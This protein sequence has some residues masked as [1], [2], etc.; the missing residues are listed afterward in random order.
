MAR[1]SCASSACLS[2]RVCRA[3]AR[4][5]SPRANAM[6]PC[7]RH[8]RRELRV[9]D[10][11]AQR[12]G[13]AAEGGGGLREVVLQQPGFGQRGPDAQLV[14]ATER[15]GSQDRP[16]SSGR[17]FGPAAA[18]QGRPPRGQ[19]WQESCE[20]PRQEYTKYPHEGKAIIWVRMPLAAHGVTHPGRRT[21]NEDTW[22]VDLDLGL[23]VVADGMGGHNAGEVASALAVKAI[24]ELFESGGDPPSQ[25][26]LDTRRPAR[27]RARS[28]AAAPATR[29]SGMGTTVVAVLRRRRARVL[30]SV[31]D[32][33]IYLWR[34]GRLHAAHQ[35]TRGSPRCWTAKA[36]RRRTSART[37]CATC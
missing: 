34:G 17:N 26:L 37:R 36:N 22:L 3:I 24:R 21:T 27:E 30:T 8:E 12:V 13:R 23:F 9:G 6:R 25:T 18:F 2:A 35:T 31:G 32:S 7:S 11:L 28:S 29:H 19:G 33:R 10:L 14:V 4:D 1:E 5:C 15:A 16:A 20:P